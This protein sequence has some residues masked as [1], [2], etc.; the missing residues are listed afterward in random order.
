MSWLYAFSVVAVAMTEAG[1]DDGDCFAGVEKHR[2]L[3][4]SKIVQACLHAELLAQPVPGLADAIGRERFARTRGL[5]EHE[6]VA[7]R[8]HAGGEPELCGLSAVLAEQLCC[9]LVEADAANRVGLGALHDELLLDFEHGSADEHAHGVGVEIDAAPLQAAH[10]AAP[11]AG[12]GSSRNTMAFSG[13]HDAAARSMTR[14][15]SPTVGGLISTRFT[16]GGAARSIGLR[17][18]R[19]HRTAWAK[20]ARSSAWKR[21]TVAGLRFPT[22][23]RWR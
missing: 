10:L 23:P 2:R 11:A 16:R 21:S 17:S 6:V 22:M 9:L 5:A 18:T 1:G 8:R 14:R 15:T 7:L 3:E 19:P 12:G 20:A 4:V 13:L